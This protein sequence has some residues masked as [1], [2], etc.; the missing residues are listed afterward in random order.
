MELPTELL[1]ALNS[2]ALVVLLALISAI[3][4]T[5]RKVV[6][7][8]SERLVA[9]IDA[10]AKTEESNAHLAALECVTR[11]LSTWAQ[12][13]VVE[14]EQ[15]LVRS[16]KREGKWNETTAREVRDAAV[17]VMKR[18]AGPAGLA[19]LQKCTGLDMEVLEGM[20]RTYIENTVATLNRTRG[21]E[22]RVPPPPPTAQ[23]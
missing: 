2:A 8:G 23:L 9:W 10:R 4:L 21:Q 17:E 1:D 11:K 13:A 5:L 19:E 18:H 6:N 7:L 22:P 15:T 14:L 3:A 20:M 12:T 16:L